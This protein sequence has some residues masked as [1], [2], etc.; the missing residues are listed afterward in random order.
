MGH[1]CIDDLQEVSVSLAPVVQHAVRHIDDL[2]HDH[3]LLVQQEAFLADLYEDGDV[4]AGLLNLKYLTP[5]RAT[6][7]VHYLHEVV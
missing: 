5:K 6:L 2:Q 1:A 7:H 4:A 3:L